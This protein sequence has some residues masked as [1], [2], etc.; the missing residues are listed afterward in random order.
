M[1]RFFTCSQFF[2]ATVF[3]ILLS[4]QSP[5]SADESAADGSRAA[6]GAIAPGDIQKTIDLLENDESR[7]EILRLLKLMAALEESGEGD[8]RPLK[9]E[10]DNNEEAEGLS[11]AAAKS[12]LAAQAAEFWRQ[13]RTIGPGLAQSWRSMAEVFS[14][15]A[16]PLALELWRPYVLKIFIWGLFCLTATW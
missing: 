13:I 4:G 9:A 2:A 1:S 14:S 6:A 5:L 12:W 3:F 8:A 11:R 10:T 7:Q 15:L 16:D